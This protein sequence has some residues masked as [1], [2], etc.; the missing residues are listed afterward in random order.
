MPASDYLTK[1]RDG[2][3]NWTPDADDSALILRV[4]DGQ[5]LGEDWNFGNMRQLVVQ[6]EPCRERLAARRPGLIRSAVEDQPTPPYLLFEPRGEHI[7]VSLFFIED[8]EIGALYPTDPAGQ[9]VERLYAFV[10]LHRAEMLSSLPDDLRI[11]TFE[12]VMCPAAALLTQLD[13]AHQIGGELLHV[14]GE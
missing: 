7:A 5:R 14:L 10:E 8:P 4:G 1:A 11:Y 9:E 12:D 6:L 2:S 3:V 13:R